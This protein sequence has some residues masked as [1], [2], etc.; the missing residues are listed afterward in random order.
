MSWLDKS[1]NNDHSV[2]SVAQ[3]E[4]N[5]RLSGL[6]LPSSPED[7]LILHAWLVSMLRYANGGSL[8]KA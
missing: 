4:E 7:C 5:V 6:K 2:F 1:K 3:C 8:L